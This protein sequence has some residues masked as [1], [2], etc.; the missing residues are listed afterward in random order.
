MYGT[1]VKIAVKPGK[2]DQLIEFLRCDAAV[3]TTSEPGVTR[4]YLERLAQLTTSA[5][6][7][8]LLDA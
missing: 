3:A 1:L 5:P 6:P 8:A 2:I 4:C 7:R